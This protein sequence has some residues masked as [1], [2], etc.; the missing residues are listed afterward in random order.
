MKYKKDVKLLKKIETKNAIIKKL[1]EVLQ[2]N[3]RIKNYFT[4][5]DFLKYLLKK[6]NSIMEC[7]R[8]SILFVD[9]QRNELFFKISS[10]EK[11]FN[12]LTKYK[13]KK[14]EGIAGI[15]WE[16]E[17]I[18]VVD[19]VRKD[20][21]YK[22]LID[23]KL[24]FKTKSIIAMPLKLNGKIIGVI[25]VLNKKNN[26]IFN[27]C[28]IF[29][30]KNLAVQATIIIQY[31]F[32]YE[33]SIIDGKTGLYAHRFLESRLFEEFKRATRYKRELSLIMF[34]IDFFK[35]LNDNYGHQFGDSVLQKIAEIIKQNCRNSDI[36]SRFG[37]EEFCVILPET[38]KDGAII[39]AERVR[40]KIEITDFG[41]NNK[42]VKVTT[43]GG[44][45]SLEGDFVESSNDLIKYAD[46]ALYTAKNNGRNKIVVYNRIFENI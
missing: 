19:D 37:G 21:R 32:L 36:P 4:N 2:I 28:D 22:T 44:I 27:K 23:E 14:G 38:N 9:D 12:E 6:I 35:N 33:I 25:E 31:S 16:T 45:S 29:L 30:F 13:I 10:N 17:E 11:E 15:V 26:K 40:K 24:N 43:S 46:E 41:Y 8:S 20:G 5:K 7:E 3:R 18:L 34:D 39:F 42:I 1:Q